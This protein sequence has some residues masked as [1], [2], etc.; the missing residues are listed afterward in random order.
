MVEKLNRLPNNSRLILTG[1]ESKEY[2]RALAK[3]L[4]D[5]NITVVGAEGIAFDYKDDSGITQEAM[6]KTQNI[7]RALKDKVTLT[8]KYEIVTRYESMFLDDIIKH[9]TH[10][11]YNDT[12]KRYF[13]NI[14]K[15]LSYLRKEEP[16]DPN[17]T[18]EQ[19]NGIEQILLNIREWKKDGDITIENLSLMSRVTAELERS[20]PKLRE[21]YEKISELF[22]G[23]PVISD[24]LDPKTFIRRVLS[25]YEKQLPKPKKIKKVTFKESALNFWGEGVFSVQ[26]YTSKDQLYISSFMEGIKDATPKQGEQESIINYIKKQYK[27]YGKIAAN[28]YVKRLVHEYSEIPEAPI[29]KGWH[30]FKGEQDA[31]IMYDTYRQAADAQNPQ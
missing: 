1:C 4:Q 16:D 30:A 18:D 11:S 9:V 17:V 25:D 13:Y 5:K 7:P 2:A 19:R 10:G 6:F 24:K 31:V 27:H 26:I 12:N 22:P 28:E 29:E 8:N 23:T 3:M 15:E 21:M 14:L 20:F